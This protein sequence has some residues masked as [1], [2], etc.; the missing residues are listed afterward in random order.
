M[1]K[2]R[3]PI[4]IPNDVYGVTVFSPVQFFDFKN[5]YAHILEM[6]K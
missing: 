6:F 1:F 3:T 4:N 2:V 5:I